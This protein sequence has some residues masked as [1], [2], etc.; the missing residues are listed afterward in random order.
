MKG[1]LSKKSYGSYGQKTKRPTQTQRLTTPRERLAW[2][3]S[4]LARTERAKNPERGTEHSG[5]TRPC[6]NSGN[7]AKKSPTGTAKNRA[8]LRR[9]Q[10]RKKSL[11]TRHV[12]QN[13]ERYKSRRRR[14]RREST[15]RSKKGMTKNII[16]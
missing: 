14:F 1:H 4:L 11:Q 2:T 9:G 7:A 10:K 3:T 5:R 6:I 15:S 12:R 8:H 16:R 13:R